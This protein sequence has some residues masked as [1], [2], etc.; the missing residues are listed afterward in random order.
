MFVLDTPDLEKL[1]NS[2]RRT[3]NFYQVPIVNIDHHAN[4][5]GYGQIKLLDPVATSTSEIVFEFI[6]ELDGIEI[7]EYMATNL[8]TGIIS[9]TRSFQ[10]QSVTPRSLSIA[11]HLVAQGARREDIV[12]NLYQNKSLGTLR[13][14]GLVL[15][16]LQYE[17]RLECV[18]SAITAAEAQIPITD[19]DLE[20][21]I[22]ELI[23]NAP[24]AKQVMI[25][26]EEEPHKIR[27]ILS[28]PPTLDARVLLNGLHPEG[29]AD[30]TWFTTT[31]ESPETVAKDVL[32]RIAKYFQTRNGTA[33]LKTNPSS[34]L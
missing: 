13:L 18:W 17:E 23:V 22:D 27:G 25:L 21:V 32:D 15:S 29:S 1:G 26:C 19:K 12:K 20:G 30:F 33:P 9:K 10:T 14:W 6:K 2:T 28:T 3:R 34:I 11:S 31:G 7:D 24:E 4:N 8:L 16:K 5:E